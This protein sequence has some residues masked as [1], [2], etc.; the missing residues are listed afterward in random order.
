MSRCGRTVLA[1]AASRHGGTQ[2]REVNG[3]WCLQVVLQALA[4]LLN[5]SSKFAHLDAMLTSESSLPWP[6]WS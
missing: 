3:V 4:E 2:G 5:A 1:P 6:K